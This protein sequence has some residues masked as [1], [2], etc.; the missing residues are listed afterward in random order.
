M[1]DSLWDGRSF[2]LLNVIDDYNRQVLHIESDTSL[3]ALRVIRVLSQLSET[4]GLPN[5]IRVD[6][7]PE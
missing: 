1:H 7:G 5:M 4:R 3:P 6:N 2:R